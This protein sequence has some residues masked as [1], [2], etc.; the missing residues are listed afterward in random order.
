MPDKRQKTDC[1]GM[2]SLRDLVQRWNMA[3]PNR[4]RR[5]LVLRKDV[6]KLAAR[7]LLP[8]TGDHFYLVEWTD[9]SVRASWV[10]EARLAYDP[11]EE[12]VPL[13][14]SP[15]QLS[16]AKS[17]CFWVTFR[18]SFLPLLQEQLCHGRWIKRTSMVNEFAFSCYCPIVAYVRLFASAQGAVVTEMESGMVKVDFPHPSALPPEIVGCPTASRFEEHVVWGTVRH[19]WWRVER[20]SPSVKFQHAANGEWYPQREL[21]IIAEPVRFRFHPWKERLLVSMTFAYATRSVVA[22][23]WNYHNWWGEPDPGWE[24]KGDAVQA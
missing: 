19:A 20:D 24:S 4:R 15:R 23:R 13:V 10:H 5:R 3:S 1:P 17:H 21:S 2:Q 6:A 18:E 11:E 7:C 12:G 16:F 9:T 14:E 8:E 22:P